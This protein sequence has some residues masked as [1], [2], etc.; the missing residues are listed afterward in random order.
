MIFCN[1]DK[2]V[3]KQYSHFI[4][5]NIPKLLD[6][7]KKYNRKNLFDIFIQFKDLISLSLSINQNEL[8]LKNGLDFDTFRNCILEIQDEK[9]KFAKSLFSHINKSDYSVLNIKDFIKGM[10]FIKNSDLTEKLELFSNSLD[11]SN[12][13]EISFQEAIRISKNSISKYLDKNFKYEFKDL[14]MKELSEYLATFIFQLA[15]IKQNESI[16]IDDLKKVIKKH[17]NNKNTIYNKII[18]LN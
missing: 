14:I 7:Y 3:N 2:K 6:D 10:Y 16:K 9:Y 18:L 11:I 13:S 1:I 5:Y 4:S 8:I 15:G 12:K 17:S